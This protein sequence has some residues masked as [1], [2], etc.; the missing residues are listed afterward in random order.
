MSEKK[1]DKEK[2]SNFLITL[3]TNR[4]PESQ[5]QQSEMARKL[6]KGASRLLKDHDRVEEILKFMEPGV[7]YGDGRVKSVT[8]K[9]AV[10][11]GPK[12]GR[13]HLHLFVRVIH[14]TKIHIDRQGLQEAMKELTGIDFPYVNIRHVKANPFSEVEQYL[15]KDN[16]WYSSSDEEE[17]GWSDGDEE[18][19][20][21]ASHMAKTLTIRT[22]P[23]K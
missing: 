11:R 19:S 13:M 1:K 23:G 10:E 3:N 2:Y 22:S 4:Y 14:D 8:S 21:I 5:M 9:I 6:Y 17:V 16:L 7:E 12:L 18:V 15:E 20:E